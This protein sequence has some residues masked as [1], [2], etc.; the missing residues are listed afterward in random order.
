MALR[1]EFD[2][3]DCMA[4]K[5]TAEAITNEIIATLPWDRR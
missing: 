2:R 4:A 5:Y 3:G 1:E